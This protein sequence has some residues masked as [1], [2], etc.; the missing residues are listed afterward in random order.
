MESRKQL[1]KK[2][3]QLINSLNKE[4]LNEA[5]ELLQLIS[6]TNKINVHLPSL[7]NIKYYHTNIGTTL[8]NV[9]INDENIGSHQIPHD[10]PLK[11]NVTN[12]VHEYILN[13]AE[14]YAESPNYVLKSI[15]D[16]NF[17]SGD[18]VAY[19]GYVFYMKYNGS[20][21]YLYVTE[22]D[23]LQH[24]NYFII[25]IR[26]T[27]KL[28]PINELAKEITLYNERYN[29]YNNDYTSSE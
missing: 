13:Y 10:A 7:S 17:R 11:R 27:L 2:T 15:N 29:M 1:K 16:V 9:T 28:V 4:Q 6:S 24:V 25:S 23:F 5:V 20:V 3:F 14:K 12:L 8:L 21:S 22:Q 26:K 18:K 19:N